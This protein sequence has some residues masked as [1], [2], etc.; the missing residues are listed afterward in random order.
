VQ[1]EGNLA[2]PTIRLKRR[3]AA[4]TAK[5]TRNTVRVWIGEEAVMKA[6]FR[7]LS[8][9]EN[10]SMSVTRR[11]TGKKNNTIGTNM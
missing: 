4:T 11:R 10:D 7:G 5:R 3:S 6:K 9:S 8:A 2:A 1:V